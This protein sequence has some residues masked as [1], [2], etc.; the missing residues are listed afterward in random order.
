MPS[1]CENG[2]IDGYTLD[3][4]D[5]ITCPNQDLKPEKLDLDT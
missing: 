3:S 4:E 1:V 5:G 2:A